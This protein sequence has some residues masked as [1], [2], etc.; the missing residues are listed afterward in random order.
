MGSSKKPIIA[1]V[2]ILLRFKNND[3]EKDND[4]NGVI[5]KQTIH[6]LRCCSYIKVIPFDT[7]WVST[8][9]AF[10]VPPKRN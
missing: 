7:I 8:S 5:K 1:W 2:Y 6:I 4:L 9:S 10:Y 3:N